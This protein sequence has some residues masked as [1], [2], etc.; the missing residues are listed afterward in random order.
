MGHC[1]RA[2]FGDLL[3]ET[4]D[5]GAVGAE[6]VAETGGHELGSALLLDGFDGKA[7]G[8]DVDFRQTFGA[9]HDI[10]R[11]DCLVGGHHDHLLDI[12]FYTFVSYVA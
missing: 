2:A 11:V 1:H 3:T 5:D 6:D 7:E 12:I 8:L 10:G 4:R 9:T